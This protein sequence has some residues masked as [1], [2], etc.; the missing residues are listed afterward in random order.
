MGTPSR[1]RLACDLAR[2]AGARIGGLFRQRAELSVAFKAAGDPVSDADRAVE[3]MIVAAIAA[4]FAED[5][6][7]GEEYGHQ[8]DPQAR[9]CWV[10]DPIDG[11]ANFIRG[12]PFFCVSIAVLCDGRPEIGCIYDPIAEELFHARVGA[13]AWCGGERLSGA[14]AEGLAGAM[15]GLGYNR[16]A[17][18]ARLA[19]IARRVFAA[20][21]DIRRMSA[22]ALMLAHV[23]AGRLDGYVEDQMNSWD[24]LAGLVLNAEAG[25]ARSAPWPEQP[26]ETPGTVRVGA[27]P[28]L[29]AL[30]EI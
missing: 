29:A 16:H 9:Y 20:R 18:G 5:A 25:N 13:G 7:F 2:D 30:Q 21:G 27:Q 14:R 23:A 11:T 24:A 28:V 8:G 6:V 10:I 26:L 22:G 4:E 3:R 17:D 1:H 19:D 15:V 12:I